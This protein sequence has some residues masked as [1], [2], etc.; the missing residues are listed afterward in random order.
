MPPQRAIKGHPIFHNI[1]EQ[2]LPNAPEVQPQGEIINFKLR[3]A[4]R[5]FTHAI[6][7]KCW[8]QS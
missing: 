2:G 3:E 6:T 7:N 8:H 4:I 5:M 1:E